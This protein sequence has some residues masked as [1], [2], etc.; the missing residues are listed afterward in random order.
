MSDLQITDDGLGIKDGSL[1]I[2]GGVEKVRQHIIIA[3]NTFYN[4][5]ILDSTKGIDY[6]LGLRDM[7]FLEYDVKKQLKEV[8]DVESVED[9]SMDFDRETLTVNITAQIKTAY[10]MLDLSESIIQY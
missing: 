3:L 5:W 7:E 4:D 6:A 10:G 1:I 8:E 2:I 9:F